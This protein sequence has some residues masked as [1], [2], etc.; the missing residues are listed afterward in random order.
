MSWSCLC[1]VRVFS[2][3]RAPT[4]GSHWRWELK[5]SRQPQPLV[6]TTSTAP[7]L[8]RPLMWVGQGE[9]CTTQGLEVLGW[10]RQPLPPHGPGMG[11]PCWVPSTQH[12]T[13][14]LKRSHVQSWE[15]R[16]PARTRRHGTRCLEK[17]STGGAGVKEPGE[18]A[19]R[20]PGESFLMCS[21]WLPASQLLLEIWA[22][23]SAAS[24]ERR[25]SRRK[26]IAPKKEQR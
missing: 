16:Q 10:G 2:T 4:C 25:A 12:H 17:R 19:T 24:Q 3:V 7:P 21:A 15:W 8:P 26:D 22:A 1:R 18:P 5:V 20:L 23:W 14:E 9:S 6:R 13:P 11:I